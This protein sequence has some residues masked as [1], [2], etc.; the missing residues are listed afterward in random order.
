MRASSALNYI[1]SQPNPWACSRWPHTSPP[2][3]A[4]Y[5]LIL[6]ESR[7]LPAFL[8]MIFQMYS[9]F[10]WKIKIGGKWLQLWKDPSLIEGNRAVQKIQHS[11]FTSGERTTLNETSIKTKRLATGAHGGPRWLWPSSSLIIAMQILWMW[12]NIQQRSGASAILFER[13]DSF[14][15][16]WSFLLEAY[17]HPFRINIFATARPLKPDWRKEQ[18]W[19]GR[20]RGSLAVL[21]TL[22]GVFIILSAVSRFTR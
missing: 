8:S 20:Y 16:D 4:R 9:S 13:K 1:L 19:D 3:G 10:G 17:W 5:G 6:P 15:R 21:T 14:H 12:A 7:Y 22:E 2:D 18:I 11:L